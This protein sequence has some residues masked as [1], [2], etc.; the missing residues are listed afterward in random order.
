MSEEIEE[1]INFLGTK[2]KPRK[3]D[4]TK[5]LD[6]LD[7]IYTYPEMLSM[8]YKSME[9]DG[10]LINSNLIKLNALII[11]LEGSRIVIKEWSK[12]IAS[13]NRDQ[14]HLQNYISKELST[15]ISYNIDKDNLYIKGR[16][17][18]AEIESII[19]KYIKTF[20][21]CYSCKSLN[22]NFCRKNRTMFIKCNKCGCEKGLNKATK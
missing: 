14:T 16:F 8:L 19:K 17:S 10:L 22:T 20:I 2:K 7:N 21:I 11:G 5:N 4:I 3:S 18:R 15:T 12:V 1:D 13:V 6:T 9:H